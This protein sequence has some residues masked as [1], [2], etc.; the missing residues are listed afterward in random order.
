MKRSLGILFAAGVLAA[1]TACSQAPV[2]TSA[3]PASHDA[4][5][6]AIKDLETQWNKDAAAKDLNGIVSHYAPDAVLMIPG[7]PAA[8]GKDA[9]LAT[10]KDLL[11]D[12]NASLKFAASRVDVSGDLAY[13]QGN[14][15]LTVTDPATKKPVNDK[16]SYVTVYRRQGDG[17]WKAVSDIASSSVPPPAPP[18]SK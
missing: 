6:Q 13:T 11:S 18:K 15:D 17:S 4:D 12:P 8:S 14:Y 1:L 16:G 7:S 9:I 2:A 10:H 3:S 5:V